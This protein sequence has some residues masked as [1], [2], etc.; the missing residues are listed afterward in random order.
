[1]IFNPPPE[2]LPKELGRRGG[3]GLA[4][5]TGILLIVIAPVA[6]EIFF[7]GF[8]YQAFRNSFGVLAGRAS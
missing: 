7:R 1:M 4:I 2:E 5:A 6:E 3:C 8:L